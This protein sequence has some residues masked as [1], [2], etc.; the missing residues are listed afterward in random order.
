M[1]NEKEEKRKEDKRDKLWGDLEAQ[2]QARAEHKDISFRLEGDW[3]KFVRKEL[4][5]N[6]YSVNGTWV[7]NNLSAYFGHGG[8]GY[9]HEFIPLDEIWVSTHHYHEGKEQIANCI[10]KV[11]EPNQEVSKNYFESTIIHEIAEC[12]EM[13]K[14]IAF[15]EA[16]QIALAKELESGLPDLLYEDL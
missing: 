7:R 10:C 11:R 6:I 12:E 1:E 14:G 3:K 2:I 9:V 13:K 15:F 4:S 5:Y 16:H 8:H